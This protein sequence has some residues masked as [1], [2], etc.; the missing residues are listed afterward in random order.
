MPAGQLVH[1]CSN[2]QTVF[3]NAGQKRFLRPVLGSRLF[4]NRIGTHKKLPPERMRKLSVRNC[5]QIGCE[6]SA[7]ITCDERLRSCSLG[8]KYTRQSSQ[9]GVPQSASCLAESKDEMLIDP[10]LSSLKKDGAETHAKQ[11]RIHALKN[12]TTPMTSA[13]NKRAGLLHHRVTA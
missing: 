8:V 4:F 13:A 6:N 5:L 3:K 1:L 11:R 10:D 9:R 7:G 2:E 12:K